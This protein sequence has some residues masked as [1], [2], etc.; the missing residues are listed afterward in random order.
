M[1][2]LTTQDVVLAN[3][4]D[5]SSWST[6]PNTRELT[7]EEIDAV[8]GSWIQAAIFVAAALIGIAWGSIKIY[9]HFTSPDPVPTGWDFTYSWRGVT[10]SGKCTENGPREYRFHNFETNEVFIV[11]CP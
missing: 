5:D 9:E 1:D 7:V 3:P 8:A 2:M 11:R 4:I 6:V 10:I